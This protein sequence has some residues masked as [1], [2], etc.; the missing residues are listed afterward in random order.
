LVER[1]PKPLHLLPG[2]PVNPREDNDVGNHSN[3]PPSRPFP[4][5]RHGNHRG[6][7]SAIQ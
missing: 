3:L 2:D 5:P 7:Q 4:M 1:F 6:V